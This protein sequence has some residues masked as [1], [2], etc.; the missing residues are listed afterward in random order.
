MDSDYSQMIKLREEGDCRPLRDSCAENALRNDGTT[1]W[2]SL[3]ATSYSRTKKWRVTTYKQFSVNSDKLQITHP[4]TG[5]TIPANQHT[6]WHLSGVTEE[7]H[8]KSVS[9]API[10]PKI[11]VDKT[12]TEVIVYL[13]D[14]SSRSLRNACFHTKLHGIVPYASNRH[15]NVV[16]TLKPH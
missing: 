4:M 9:T 8:E 12:E 5:Q 1:V 13:E 15:K 7:S 10:P 6:I 14:T 16:I 3:P 11:R 2:T